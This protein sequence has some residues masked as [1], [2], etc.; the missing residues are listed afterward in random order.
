MSL[1]PGDQDGVRSKAW[2]SR[3][4]AIQRELEIWMQ[5][6]LMGKGFGIQFEE[7]RTGLS[8]G[9]GGFRHN[10]WSAS[11]AESG[12]LGLAGYML[13]PISAMWVGFLLVR[14][15]TDK[16]TMYVGA[17]AAVVGCATF[18]LSF[19]TLSINTQ[20]QAIPLG[21]ICGMVYR[22]RSIQQALE[23]QGAG[24]Y[25]TGE[26]SA[27]LMGEAEYELSPR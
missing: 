13:P 22:C 3:L 2:D 15:A 11:L 14:R 26:D 12:P 20:R 16:G 21:L 19:M 1:L 10:V 17:L 7:E 4:P 25:E 23:S 6:P 27:P 24:Y 9:R 8:S 5:N 18:M